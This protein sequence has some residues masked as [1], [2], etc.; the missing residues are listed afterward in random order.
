[1]VGAALTKPFVCHFVVL[2]ILLKTLKNQHATGI[3]QDDRGERPQAC[4][5][6][7]RQ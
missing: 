7:A 5:A 2:I 6:A 4:F 1:M 3:R